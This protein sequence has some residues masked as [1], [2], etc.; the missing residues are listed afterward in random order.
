MRFNSSFVLH[1]R[2]FNRIFI[3]LWYTS[4]STDSEAETQKEFRTKLEA[5]EE[6]K[7]GK[8]IDDV[9]VQ[10]G[11]SIDYIRISKS[12]KHT[13]SAKI[14]SKWQCAY[15]LKEQSQKTRN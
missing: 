3:G 8:P 4:R 14:S 9:C 5:I 11:I 12:H 15:P 7:A 13:S 1:C 10:F 6:A 2:S